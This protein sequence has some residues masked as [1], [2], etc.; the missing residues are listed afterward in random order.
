MLE[1]VK[2]GDNLLVSSSNGSSG[3]AT[4]KRITPKGF[5]VATYGDSEVT[6]RR[7]GNERTSDTWHWKTARP[8]TDED[9]ADMRLEAMRNKVHRLIDSYIGTLTA[10]Q[11]QKIMDIIKGD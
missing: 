11:C 7:D 10:E 6:F 1:N 2:V 8:I 9:I 5:V 3:V 4:V